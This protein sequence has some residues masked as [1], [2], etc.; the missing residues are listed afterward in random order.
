LEAGA[1]KPLVED[2][3]GKINF[4]VPVTEFKFNHHVIAGAPAGT[5][6]H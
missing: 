5:V 4:A 3:R 2:G 6:Y 1:V